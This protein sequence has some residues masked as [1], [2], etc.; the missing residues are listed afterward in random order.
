[1]RNRPAQI[2]HQSQGNSVLAAA[3]Q[4]IRSCLVIAAAML[5]TAVT[6]G[7]WGDSPTSASTSP[8]VPLF[9]SR[10]LDTRGGA[11]VGNAAGTGTPFALQVLGKG[12]V[13]STGVGAV[14]LNVTVTQTEDPTIGGGYVTVYACGT[15]PDA[16]NLNFVSGQTIPNSVI[17]A[18]SSSGEICFYVYGTAHLIADVSGYFANSTPAPPSTPPP[19]STTTTTTAP[20]LNPLNIRFDGY[21]CDE[22]QSASGWVSQLAVLV[23]HDGDDEVPVEV[24]YEAQDGSLT[25]RQLVELNPGATFGL[26]YVPWPRVSAVYPSLEFHT[27]RDTTQVRVSYEGN[28]IL[29]RTVTLDDVRTE[30]PACAPV[31]DTPGVVG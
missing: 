30:E 18:V 24:T 15:R 25:T 16:S 12:G 20:N 11:K 10:V 21:A 31:V 23:R 19:A 3:P 29:D 6:V 2:R 5:V 8:F 4:R 28:V 27:F 9:P 14:A 22:Y 7:L 1:M 17:A 13:P 26:G